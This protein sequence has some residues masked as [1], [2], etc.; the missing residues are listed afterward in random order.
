VQGRPRQFILHGSLTGIPAA[1]QVVRCDC[2]V[3]AARR[4]HFDA[5][6]FTINRVTNRRDPKMS[7]RM[8]NEVDVRKSNREC[9]DG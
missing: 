8:E 6:Q 2:A 3:V 4:E 1:V 9:A 5:A 7:E